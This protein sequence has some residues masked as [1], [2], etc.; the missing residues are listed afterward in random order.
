MSDL[1]IGLHKFYIALYLRFGA[2]K[3]IWEKKKKKFKIYYRS[4]PSRPII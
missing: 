3:G 4:I 1:P 2:F